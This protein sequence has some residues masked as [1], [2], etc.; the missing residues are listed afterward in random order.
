M[1]RRIFAILVLGLGAAALAFVL[2]GGSP[3]QGGQATP[4]PVPSG[5]AEPEP[6]PEPAPEPEGTSF[7]TYSFEKL[8][9]ISAEI[10]AAGGGE[11][12]RE[13]ARRYGLVD[14]Q[15]RLTD[16]VRLVTL[17]DGRELG[18][19]LAGI[20]HDKRPD[21]SLVGLTLVTDRAV[22][23]RPMNSSG[24]NAGGWEASELRSW[25]GGECLALL[26]DDLASAAVEVS[27]LTNNTGAGRD[28][29]Q[30]TATSDRLWLLSG[31]E[32]VGEIDWFVQEFD[33][34]YSW[35]DDVANAEGEQYERFAAAGRSYG[36][37][38]VAWWYR[39]PYY[40][41]FDGF[42]GGTYF[43]AVLSAGYPAGHFPPETE[44]GVVFGLCI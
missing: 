17:D 29:S 25:L 11:P 30:V 16:E 12:S 34:G 1:F 26:P 24:T 38:P 39:T 8:S 13:V 27:Q 32:V 6:E 43:Y 19:L 15:N 20:C 5:Q 42:E 4:D 44:A 22:A 18:F 10:A 33:S 9:A 7:A 28:V 36:G 37:D 40:V 3:D 2:I 14:D 41:A 35:W 21:G 23:M 31:R